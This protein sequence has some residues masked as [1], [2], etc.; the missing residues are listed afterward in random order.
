[1]SECK[2]LPSFTRL[3]PIWMRKYAGSAHSAGAHRTSPP[4]AASAL[5]AAQGTTGQRV[6]ESTYTTRVTRRVCRSVAWIQLVGVG[7]EAPRI[8]NLRVLS[9]MLSYGEQRQYPSV[10]KV[11]PDGRVRV[12]KRL[13]ALARRTDP[14]TMNG[15]TA[16]V[17]VLGRA[18]ARHTSSLARRVR[19]DSSVAGSLVSAPPPAADIRLGGAGLAIS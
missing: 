6:I 5:P 7:H 17:N 8:L 18:A 9:Q 1:V 11:D 3:V 2:P 13:G 14:A 15:T 4:L 10:P 12:P 19:G 16:A